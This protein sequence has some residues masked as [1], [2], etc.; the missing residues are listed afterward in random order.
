M[1]DQ[2]ALYGLLRKMHDI[3]LPLLSVIHIK[4]KPA[5]APHANADMDHNHS[6]KETNT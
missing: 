2:A 1:V 3:G 6:T 5:N 4:P